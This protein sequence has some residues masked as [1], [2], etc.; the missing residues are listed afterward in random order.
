MNQAYGSVHVAAGAATPRHHYT[1]TDGR[2]SVEIAAGSLIVY[3]TGTPED[4][5]AFGG[6]LL[7]VAADLGAQ[8][9]A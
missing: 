9:S 4:L 5:F 6:G 8:V 1:H 7:E 2:H 3:L